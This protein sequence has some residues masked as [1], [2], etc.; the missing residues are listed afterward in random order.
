MT[1][2]TGI[3]LKVQDYKENDGLAWMLTEDEIICVRVRGIQKESSKLRSGCQPFLYANWQIEKRQQAMGL[4]IQVTP[5][6]FFYR[7]M[8][9][10]IIQALSFLLKD[11]L[12]KTKQNQ[13]L[14]S[15]FL[16]YLYTIQNQKDSV[17]TNACFVLKE[18]LC[19]E[20]IQPY[21]DGCI[22]CHR[23]DALET[24]SVK[25]GGFLCHYCNHDEKKIS[26]EQMKKAYLLFKSSKERLD[27]LHEN[28]HFDIQDCIF[29]AKWYEVFEQTHL[30]SL[31]FLKN[32]VK[33]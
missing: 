20:G 2:V 3:V 24:I 29:W 18:V 27:L 16:E 23:K 33:L 10:L 15:S 6:C 1:S 22:L 26:K 28:C 19:A 4:L 5:I 32:V 17:F 8:D 31:T 9:D 14:Y 21:V 13:K 11:I 7:F 12:L 30:T 25:E